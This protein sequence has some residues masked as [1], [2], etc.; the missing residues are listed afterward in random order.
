MLTLPCTEGVKPVQYDT[1]LYSKYSS[2]VLDY[3][4]RVQY[5]TRTGQYNNTTLQYEELVA[6]K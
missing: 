2:T 6:F 3:S 5:I 1:V 4:S